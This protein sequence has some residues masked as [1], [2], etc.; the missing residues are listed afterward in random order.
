MRALS[1]IVQIKLV[2]TDKMIKS[3]HGSRTRYQQY[4][5]E[6]R[7]ANFAK[8]MTNLKRKQVESEIKLLEEKKKKITATVT[9]DNETIDFQI[10][11][12]QNGLQ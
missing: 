4:I 12:L 1:F 11:S 9:R 2:V 5:E 10:A 3:V 7:A 6:E 8:N